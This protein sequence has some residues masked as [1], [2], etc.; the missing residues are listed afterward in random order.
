MASSL[1]ERGMPSSGHDAP[2]STLPLAK[3][4]RSN[5]WIEM[6]LL[7]L[8]AAKQKEWKDWKRNNPQQNLIATLEH[9]ASI[10][11]FMISNGVQ[12]RYAN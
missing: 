9:W 8:V 4:Q 2:Q 12:D 11:E 10:A 7:I 3:W 5:N 6:E 1:E